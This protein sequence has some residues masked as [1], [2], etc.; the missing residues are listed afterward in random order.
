MIFFI[1]CTFSV[2]QYRIY[3]FVNRSA[4]CVIVLD[5][6]IDNNQKQQLIKKLKNI[7]FQDVNIEERNDVIYVKIKC[8][9]EKFSFFSKWILEKYKKGEK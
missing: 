2:Y 9:P 3:S 4:E 5:E 8:P 1:V 6:K 7:T